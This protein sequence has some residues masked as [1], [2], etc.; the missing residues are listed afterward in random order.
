[1]A[2]SFWFEGAMPT[3]PDPVQGYIIPIIIHGR[4]VYLPSLYQTLR[5][6]ALVL[7]LMLVCVAAV[8]DYRKDP[9][10]RWG[11]PYVLR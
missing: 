11:R 6:V 4:T 10:R 8:I 7:G 5:T 2:A 3:A 9:H 1:M